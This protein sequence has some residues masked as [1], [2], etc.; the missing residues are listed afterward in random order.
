MSPN[1]SLLYFYHSLIS[2][3]LKNYQDALYLI[4]MAI[5][6]I[7]ELVSEYHFIEGLAYSLM[8]QI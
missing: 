8:Y 7:D 5:S 3:Y 4:R 6:T 2:L 1:Y